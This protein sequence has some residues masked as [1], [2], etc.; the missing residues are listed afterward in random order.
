MKTIRYS[1]DMDVLFIE[2][3]DKLI[4]CVEDKGNFI[5]HYS[6]DMEPVLIEIL[7]AKEFLLKIIASIIQET[8]IVIP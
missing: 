1:K 5:I 3:S 2:L 8:E 7:E 4:E 6:K